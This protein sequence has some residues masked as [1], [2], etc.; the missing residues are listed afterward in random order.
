MAITRFQDAPSTNTPINSANLNGNFDEL[1]AKVGTSIDSNYKTNIIKGKNLFNKNNYNSINGYI[2]SG[3]TTISATG[4][5]VKILYIPCKPNTTYTIQ[6]VA[7]KRFSVGTTRTTPAVGVNYYDGVYGNTTT[8][9]L[10]ITTESQAKYLIVEY[11]LGGSSSPDTLTEAQIVDTIQIEKGSTATTYEAYITPT[12]NVDSEDIYVKGQNDFYSKQ[13][14]RIGT[15]IDGKPIYRKVAQ[16]SYASGSTTAS[17]SFDLPNLD[18]ITKID[19]LIL[20][21]GSQDKFESSYYSSSSDYLRVFYR[22]GNLEVRSSSTPNPYII[23]V[24]LEYTKT[25]D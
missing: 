9:E 10:T 14:Q 21:Q 18:I 7:S 15:W 25:T 17:Q 13:E 11:Y 5:G 8:T 1:G 24:T 23:Y 20:T 2:L 4:S 3:N 6:K 22:G 12:I 19:T 16:I